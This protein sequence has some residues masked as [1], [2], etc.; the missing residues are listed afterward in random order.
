MGYRGFGR[1]HRK[2]FT[3]LASRG[4]AE[5]G[6]K[7][8][9]YLPIRLEGEERMAVGA[10]VSIGPGCWLH[11]EGDEQEVALEIDDQARIGAYSTLSAMHS[12]KIGKHALLGPHVFVSD[13]GHEFEDPT[14][15]ILFQ[16]LT[17]TAAVE[18][19]DGAWLGYGV[20]VV[21]GVRIGAGAVIGANSVVTSDI[22]DNA[23]AVGAPA[24]V[25]RSRTSAESQ[26]LLPSS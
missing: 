7:S 11:V 12:L 22:P 19:G 5:F 21:P 8:V 10:G 14:E 15:P 17:T 3:V 25:V 2:A 24:R 9:I 4:F 6:P 26:P 20:V 1:A 18:I 13:H 16:G 23:I